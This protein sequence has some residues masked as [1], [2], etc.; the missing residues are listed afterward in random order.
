MRGGDLPEVPRPAPDRPLRCD[1]RQWGKPDQLVA[2]RATTRD[3]LHDELGDLVPVAAEPALRSLQCQHGAPDHVTVEVLGLDRF[4]M[5][6]ADPP[7]RRRLGDDDHASVRVLRIDDPLPEEVR[8]PRVAQLQCVDHVGGALPTPEGRQP[9][10][11]QREQ[12]RVV[13]PIEPG[14]ESGVYPPEPP[15]A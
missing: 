3:V 10:D 6:G 13:I 1:P 2:E 11:A 15:A 5:V 8:V 4:G 12:P 9:G 7:G 14:L